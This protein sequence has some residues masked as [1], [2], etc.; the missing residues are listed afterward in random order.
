MKPFASL[1]RAVR[2]S[3]V[4]V[5]ALLA[6]AILIPVALTPLVAA[7]VHAFARARGL[8][9][10]WSQLAFGWPATV[11]LRD[12]TLRRSADG[13][14]VL[15]V[16]RVE[17]ALAPR[18]GS[19]RP[20]V[21][22]LVLE[23]ASAVLP[24]GSSE[25]DTSAVAPDDP[26]GPSGPAAPRVRAA[27]E[28]LAEALL[29]PARRLPEL[30]LSD[31]DVVHSARAQATRPAGSAPAQS[32][33]SLVARFD[34]LSLEHH[35]G[36]AQFAAVGVLGGEHRVPFDVS[37]QWRSDDGVVGRASFRIP[38]ERHFDAPVAI[39]I[40]GRV[41]QDR[42]AGVLRVE[43][44]THVSVGQ[45]EM[46]I[47]GDV[48]RAGPRFR[49]ALEMDHLSADAVQQSLPRAV[50]GP[51]RDL[52]V[53]GS[54]DWRA[55]LDLD[56][57]RPDSTR[58]TAD[59][60]PHGL[61]LTGGASRL[62]L[63]QLARPFV[64]E[65]HVP[66][67]RIVFRDLSDSNENFRPLARISPLL[68]AAVITN[69]DGGFYQHRGFNP[70]AIQSAMAENLR[71]G[72]FRRG[73]GTITMQLA[74]NLFLGHRRTLSR[75]G[76]EVVLAWVLEHLT[77]LSKDRLLEI[78][79]NIIEWG[80]EVHGANEAAR[81]YFDKDAAELTLDE[82]LF[83]TVVVPS[84]GHWRSRVDAAGEL[85]PWARS[86]MAFIAR[87]MAEKGWLAPEQV[88]D[89]AALRVELRGQAA[90]ALPARAAGVRADTLTAA[91]A[92]PAPIGSAP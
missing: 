22:R 48:E 12:L 71:A 81:F 91:G 83:L 76:Q 26:S 25:D 5:G 29:I 84:P 90:Q 69:E 73:A 64:A 27:A 55:S 28:Q 30:L 7:G 3:L 72:A 89:A 51:L 2:V 4:V 23:H 46:S 57:A 77:G 92:G 18:L 74:R 60:I 75:K 88:P 44:G 34:A 45:T 41:T 68:R 52:S 16:G 56:V 8:E 80:P 50:L 9:A 49:L 61:A 19:L 47:A 66:P 33:D 36:G 39:L 58:F 15:V 85:R 6:L 87:K 14:G 67:D 20:R 40:D 17:A 59:V 38:D 1:P 65:I 11:R 82:A 42:H 10:R 54:W 37:F 53:T 31:M 35:A 70:G 13:A 43:P 86:Q 78:Y 24:A 32:P 62:H 79:L 21:A 63:A